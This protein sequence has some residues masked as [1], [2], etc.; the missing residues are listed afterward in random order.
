MGQTLS[1]PATQK[2]SESGSNARFHYAVTEMQGWRI[3]MEDAHAIVLDLDEGKEDPNTFFAVYDGHGGGTVAKFAGQNVHKR[4][5]TEEA[6]KESQYDEALKRA[7][8][9]TD[10]DLLANPAHTRDPSGC[11]AVAALV[12]KDKI[13]VANAGDSRSVIS[14][15]GEVKA[16][17]FDHKPSNEVEKTRISGAGGYI[18]F[19]RVNGNLALSRALGDFE[20][21]KNYNMSPEKQIIT[22]DPD[23]TCHDITDEDEFLVLACDGIWDCLSSQQVVNFIRYQVSEGKDLTEIGEMMCEHCLA[24]DTS[25][26]AGIGCD[27]MTVLIVALLHGRTK[28]EWA[29]WV[30]D[31]VKNEYGYK[32]PSTLPQLYA[33][34]RLMSFKVRREAQE[35]R[36]RARQESS[37]GDDIPGLGYGTGGLGQFARVLGSTGG[38]SFHP[39]SAIMGDNGP[40]MFGNDDSED[41][42]SGDEDLEGGRSYFKETILGRND[43]ST[44]PMQKLQAQLDEYEKDVEEHDIDEDIDSKVPQEVPISPT[45]EEQPKH[46]VNGDAK[47]PPVKQLTSPPAGDAPHPVTTVEGLMD[48]SEDPLKAA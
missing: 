46:L 2:F 31:R 14:V 24:P 47:V 32:T 44:D 33:Q 1:S 13:Y 34:S 17:S 8:L 27:N 39:G 25:S 35:A 43:E 23:V 29:A 41:E 26:G 11:T 5:V 28:E 12:T 19:G 4:L 22:A 9:G 21:K 10:E 18:E 42:E 3:T 16:L 15:K 38:I 6:Y 36:D 30:T 48:T 45:P 7:F 40:L 37:S 20:F